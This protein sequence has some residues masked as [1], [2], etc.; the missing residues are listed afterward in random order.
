MGE[1]RTLS[2]SRNGAL[3][4]IRKLFW[5]RVSLFGKWSHDGRESANKKVKNYQKSEPSNSFRRERNL[6]VVTAR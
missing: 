3:R 5:A 2:V 1:A 4:A 6:N